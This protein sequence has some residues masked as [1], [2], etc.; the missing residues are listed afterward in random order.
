MRDYFL[1]LLREA[2]AACRLDLVAQ[3]ELPRRRFATMTDDR[4]TKET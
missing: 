2:A 3:R 1:D 4:S